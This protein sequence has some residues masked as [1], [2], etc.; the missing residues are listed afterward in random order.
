MKYFSTENGN[1]IGFKQSAMYFIAGV[2]N[3][4]SRNEI[5]AKYVI[6][7]KGEPEEKLNKDA[8]T[9]VMNYSLADVKL[10]GDN[11]NAGYRASYEFHK[12]NLNR[13][14]IKLVMN[15]TKQA[16]K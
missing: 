16:K 7:I 11:V 12:N 10:P 6:E 4:G 13:F 1:F 5:R 2:K 9:E 14:S 3:A 8:D 15:E